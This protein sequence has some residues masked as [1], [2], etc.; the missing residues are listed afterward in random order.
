MRTIVHLSDLHF[1]RLDNA[2]VDP[3]GEIVR[4]M[5]PNLVV[6]SG[7]L[8]QRARTSQFQAAAAFLN[9]LLV[10]WLAVPGNHDVPLHNLFARFFRPLANYRRYIHEIPRPRFTAMTRSWY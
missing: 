9:T 7:D 2:L 3:L 5:R 6:V 10:P 8:T 1:G 4:A